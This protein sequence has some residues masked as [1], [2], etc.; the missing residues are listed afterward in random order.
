ME[1]ARGEDGERMSLDSKKIY[2]TTKC[3]YVAFGDGCRKESGI[4]C[5]AM[6]KKWGIQYIKQTSMTCR[7]AESTVRIAQLESISRAS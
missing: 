4:C 5:I 7:S 6:K 2:G 3:L 1:R